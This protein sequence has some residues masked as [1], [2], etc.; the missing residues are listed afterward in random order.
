MGDLDDVYTLKVWTI[1]SYHVSAYSVWRQDDEGT[2]PEDVCVD[3][4]VY[5]RSNASHAGEEYCF[6]NVDIG[7]VMECQAIDTDKTTDDIENE[8]SD[9]EEEN[10]Q[11]EEELAQEEAEGEQAEELS[12][13]LDSVDSKIE[14]LTSTATTTSRQVRQVP[15]SCDEI[16]DLVEALEAATTVA[17]RITI[18]NNILQTKITKCTTSDKLLKVVGWKIDFSGLHIFYVGQS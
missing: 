16:A 10:R 15:T 13:N 12:K 18:V 17:E 9:I 5:T 2:K 1:L 7:G 3:G 4:C 11:L 8:K 14:E 6:K